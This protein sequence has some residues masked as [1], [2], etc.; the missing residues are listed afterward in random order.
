MLNFIERRKKNIENID[1]IPVVIEKLQ[2]QEE[3]WQEQWSTQKEDY[4]KLLTRQRKS[5][6]I[7]E[8]I[9]ETLD[10]YKEKLERQNN[11][12]NNEKI[13]AGYILDYDESLHQMERVLRKSEV[14]SSE[15]VRQVHGMREQLSE[16]MKQSEIKIIK[17]SEIPVD[18]SIHEVIEICDTEYEEKNNMVCEVITPGISLRGEVLR[19]AKVT[20]YK[21]REGQYNEENNRD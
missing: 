17:D 20:A 8:E 6:T 12:R 1:K 14:E 7:T 13:F 18:F 21:Y 2:L 19:K 4:Q 10:E 5:E 16:S 3:L 9:L 15:W 11:L